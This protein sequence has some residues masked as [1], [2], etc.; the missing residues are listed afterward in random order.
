MIRHTERLV[1]WSLG[2]R[3]V[4]TACRVARMALGSVLASIG[5]LLAPT[6]A[7]AQCTNDTGFVLASGAKNIN[8]IYP[9]GLGNSLNALLSTINSVNTAFLTNTASFASVPGGAAPD[10][11][12]GGV[13]ARAVGGYTD[14]KATSV[15]VVHLNP[16]V[17]GPT[18]CTGTVHEEYHGSQ[19]GFDLYKANLG[20]G[21]ANINIGL[22]AGY[23]STHA[24]DIT[25]YNPSTYNVGSLPDPPNT[26][27]YEFPIPNF[28][29]HTEVP[30]AGLY[31]V[32]TQGGFFADTQVR[33]DFFK[34]TITDQ[35]AGISE[36]KL[37]A[38]GL[39]VTANMGYRFSLGPVWFA[40]PSVG[41]VWSRVK[42][43]DFNSPNGVTV[44]RLGAGVFD[45]FGKGFVRFNDI[46]SL[47]GR[48]S[49]R[50][51]TTITN[52]TYVWQPFAT[53]SVFHEYGENAYA[54]SVSTAG[55][56][57]GRYL[58]LS[59]DRVGTY[60]QYGLGTSLVFGS[61][62][63][64]GYGRVDYKTGE[65]VEGVNVNTGLRYQW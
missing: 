57:A 6:G 53:A 13:W 10:Q 20:G 63:W 19:F 25:T 24:K 34:S 27:I 37:N 32:F 26:T 2:M 50:V 51:G 7:S 52:G 18:T 29:T 23:F 22:T 28:S 33:F 60:A 1:A 40:E 48:A 47:L 3:G 21:G 45:T 17:T 58:A 15:G 35:S 5:L 62:G 38:Q 44:E 65:K 36:Q 14:T 11:G 8:I 55:L 56:N 54:E 61:S 41:A 9:L 30:F 49:L 39:S 64:L 4:D 46:E 42:V 59:T 43:D 12:G 16:G 31:G